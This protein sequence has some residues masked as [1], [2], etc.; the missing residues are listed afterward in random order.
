VKL[1]R[2]YSGGAWGKQAGPSVDVHILRR[3]EGGGR[4]LTG[5]E[6]ACPSTPVL[7]RNIYQRTEL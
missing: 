3:H 1:G 7:G 2:G 4:G 6:S 5:K